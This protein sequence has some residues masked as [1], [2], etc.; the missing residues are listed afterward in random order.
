MQSLQTE[1]P[2]RI[3]NYTVIGR[4]GRGAMGTVYL[5]R[6][7]GGRLLAVKV[8]RAE[9]AEDPGFRDRFR[10]EVETMRAVGGFWTAAVVDADPDARRPWLASEYVPGP[11]LHEAVSGYGVLPEPALRRLVAGLAEALSAIHAAGLVHRDLK[12]A[13]VLLAEDGPRVIDFGIAKVLRHA[14]LTATGM[15]V[16]TPGYLSPEQI[17]GGEATAASDVF[18]LGCVL[19]FAATGTGPFG[20]GDSMALL[21]RAVHARPDLGAVPAGMRPLASRCLNRRPQLRPTPADLLG[22]VGLPGQD[23]WLPDRVRTM[24]AERSTEI[25]RGVPRP[26]TRPYTRLDAPLMPPPKETP[27]GAGNR[28]V[29]RT[30]KVSAA[31]WAGVFAAAALLCGALSQSANDFGDD[32]PAVLF[33]VAFVALLVPTA[34]MVWILARPRRWV[35]VSG[36]G[37]TVGRGE[38]RHRLDW[39]GLARVRVVEDKRRPWL[40]AWLADPEAGH[41]GLGTVYSGGFRVFPVAHE[42]RPAGRR[43]EVRE[44]RAALAWYARKVYD[45]AP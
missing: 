39:S 45:P 27:P 18:A 44:L 38:Q 10:Q 7:P 1:D 34:R 22:E 6:S 32:L 30:S 29:F 33:F 37:L 43:R 4:L 23:A 42:R 8:A 35:E 26:P 41:A 12:P 25:P 13:N 19:V 28:A 17:E 14:G 15:F 31:V 24:V 5:A 16:G 21:Y 40:V 11:N 9:L 3:G 36:D 20:A 2:K